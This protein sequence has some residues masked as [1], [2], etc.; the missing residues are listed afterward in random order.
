MQPSSEE[1]DSWDEMRERIIGLGES[2]VHKSYYPLL[3]QRLGELERFRALIDETDDMIMV[4]QM[5]D[6]RCID[7]NHACSVLLEYTAEELLACNITMFVSGESQA[8]FSALLSRAQQSGRQEK[9]E[10]VMVT[11]HGQ[12]FPAD[13]SIRVAIFDRQEYG[14][15]VA[16]DT[17][18]RKKYENA[19]L[20]AQKKLNIINFLTRNE[21][22]SQVFIVRAYLDIL[23]QI[24][25]HPEEASI[26]DKLTST[27]TEI[28]RHIEFAEN[29]QEM[30]AQDP[31]WQNFNEV[32]I[33]AISH[34]PPIPITRITRIDDVALR[35]D[36]L[37]EKGLMHLMEY[38]YSRGKIIEPVRIAHNE[39]GEGLVI[40]L[41]KKGTGIPPERK[42][43]LFIWEKSKSNTENLFFVREILA[44]TS[45]SIHETG[46]PGT[47]RFELR[48]PRDGY[49]IE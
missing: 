45:I 25:R 2:S 39:S 34:L 15:I 31:R 37:F 19:L 30:G 12:R 6:H 5:P 7:A 21:I 32:L 44:I 46:D 16:H 11:S 29:Y 20:N 42:E 33:Y 23:R 17:R 24:A 38:I 3:Q 48:I 40:S 10:L 14:V 13:L 35:S 28:Q 27:T 4:M 47:I 26:L 43:S 8:D 36:P 22:K 41:E 9:T 18:E 49:R 1:P